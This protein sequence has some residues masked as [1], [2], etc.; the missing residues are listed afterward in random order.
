MYDILALVFSFALFAIFA[1]LII[2]LINASHEKN[3]KGGKKATTAIL[4]L[5]TAY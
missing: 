3:V 4:Q 2:V 1:G 5:H